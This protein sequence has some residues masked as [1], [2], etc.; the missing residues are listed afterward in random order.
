MD[1][2][3]VDVFEVTAQASGFID[4]HHDYDTKVKHEVDH[5][6]DSLI[7]ESAINKVIMKNVVHNPRNRDNKSVVTKIMQPV[8]EKITEW[9]KI[10]KSDPTI[11]NRTFAYEMRCDV[12]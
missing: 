8:S 4:I 12:V 7:L 1:L 5:S 9:D 11:L 3:C 10:M 6:I 2:L